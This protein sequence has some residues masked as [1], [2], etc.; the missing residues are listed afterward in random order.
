VWTGIEYQVASHMIAEGLIEEG[1]AIVEGVRS[2]YD[3]HVRNPWNEYECGNFYARAMASYGL[4]IAF[5][6]FRYS[7][8]TKILTIDPRLN[9]DPFR[10]FFSTASGWGNITLGSDSIEV[11]LCSGDLHIETLM[12]IRNGKTL[13]LHPSITVH[14][15]KKELIPISGPKA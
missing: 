8:A 10:C 2:R 6:G 4:L 1:T 9:I 14:A 5:S 15:G 3:G 7:A 12:V 11:D 13:T